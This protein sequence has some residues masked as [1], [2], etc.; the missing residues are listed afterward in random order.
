MPQVSMAVAAA[1]KMEAMMTALNCI[2][3]GWV[4]CLVWI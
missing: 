1:A 4:G 2:L 3:T